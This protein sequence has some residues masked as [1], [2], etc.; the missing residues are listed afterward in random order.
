MEVRTVA[1]EAREE[2]MEVRTVAMK[3][4]DCRG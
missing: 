2:A 4:Q 1:I 3:V